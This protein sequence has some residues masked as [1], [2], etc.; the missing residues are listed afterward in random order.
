[1]GCNWKIL[2]ENAMEELHIVTVHRQTMQRSTPTE[3]HAPETS[4]GQCA[5]LF[6][7]HE[8]SMALLKGDRGL[9]Q[10][11]GLVGKAAEGTY[12]AL[13]YPATTMTLTIDGV[14]TGERRPNGP[15]RTTYVHSLHFPRAT[16]ERPEFAGAVQAYFKR[17]DTTIPEDVAACERQQ[18]G[19]RARLTGRGRFSYRETLVHQADNWWLDRILDSATET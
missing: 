4:H 6:A 13:I 1:V 16:V 5:L 15:D 11:E 14:A 17:W 10:I 12:F 18:R 9:L 2:I 8:G 19:L 7:R 3:V